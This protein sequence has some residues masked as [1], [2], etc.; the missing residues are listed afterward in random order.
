MAFPAASAP[1]GVLKRGHSDLHMPAFQSLLA[2][3][4]HH[5]EPNLDSRSPAE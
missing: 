4:S 2:V 1:D 3:F 5:F